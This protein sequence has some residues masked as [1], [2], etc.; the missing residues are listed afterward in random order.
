MLIRIRPEQAQ[1]GMYIDSLVAGW[2][3]HPFWRE[4][5]AIRSHRD[6]LRVRE[7]GS[8]LFI[9]TGRGRGVSPHA[10]SNSSD[11]IA[12]RSSS[13][14]GLPKASSATSPER[15]LINTPVAGPLFGEADRAR[16]TALAKRSA[17]VVR[18]LFEDSRAGHPLATDEIMA[19]VGDV[20]NTLEANCAA[21]ASISRLKAKD[22][23]TF[24]H[25]VS[26]CAFMVVL[27]REANA[28]AETVRH[29]G[30]AG[31][32]H[33]IG[34]LSIDEAILQKTQGLDDDERAQIARHPELGYTRLA[35]E[36]GLPPVVLD[37]CLRHHERLN[38]SGYPFGLSGEGITPA[39]RIAAICD[40]YDAITSTRPYKKGRSPLQAIT[41]M[42]A[43]DDEFD[44]DLLFRFM[45]SIGVYPAGKLIR[46]RSN[47]LAIVLQSGLENRQ[48]I[49]RAFYDVVGGRFVDYDDVILGDQL[50]HDR[51]ITHEAP[52][53][54]FTGNWE[55]LRKRVR[56]GR[57]VPDGAFSKR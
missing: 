35:S 33:D 19:V 18:K 3:S 52:D 30:V 7:A 2:L 31:L 45:R 41:E 24:I 47:R 25:S 15:K 13:S 12:P 20:A 10:S 9:D 53:A 44:Q 42:D 16:A 27:G 22:E 40:V 29:L 51:A 43:L 36:P 4:S 17:T 56:S 21:F 54:W 48:P 39:V 28:S 23:Y 11:E 26:V 32:L 6:L 55:I 34:K 14:S 1:L 49:A 46:L 57:P 5:F 38:G 8:D 37:V 50:N